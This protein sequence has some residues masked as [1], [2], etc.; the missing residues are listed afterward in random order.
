MKKWIPVL[1]ALAM[2]SGC[3]RAASPQAAPSASTPADSQ[4][5]AATASSDYV[6]PS[7]IKELT[8]LPPF[9]SQDMA[10]NSVTQEVFSQNRLTLV[11]VWA[12]WCGYCVQEMPGL[13]ALSEELKEQGMGVVGMVD[14]TS[15]TREEAQEILDSAGVTYLNIYPDAQLNRDFMVLVQSLP[16]SFIVDAQ[17][18]VVSDVIVGMRSKEAYA[19]LMQ[20]ALAKME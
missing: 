6:R 1:L 19:Q 9:T 16:T 18:N 5:P 4:A 7:S 8:V 2:L 17:G 11:N 12:T 10:G 14:S 3:A 13:Q 20:D 15:C